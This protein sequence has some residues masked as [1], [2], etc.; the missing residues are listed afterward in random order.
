MATHQHQH[1]HLVETAN[2]KQLVVHGKPFLMLAAELQNSS[3]SDSEYMASVWPKM[4]E[5]NVN[6]VLGAVTWDQIEPVEGQFDFS[7]LHKCVV[8]A[9]R[10]GL[11]LVLLWF[12]SFKNGMVA[13][14]FVFKMLL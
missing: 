9:R 1:P 5:M 8:D 13:V 7:E 2:S 12:G 3:M 11:H 6:T 4:V 14:A 10:H